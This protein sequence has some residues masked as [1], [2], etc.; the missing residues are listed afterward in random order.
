MKRNQ[1]LNTEYLN[2]KR[3]TLNA[4]FSLVE[5]LFY[6]VILS[7]ALLAVTQTLMVITRSYGILKSVQSIEQE[8]AFSL[9]R[10]MRE[11][12]NANAIDDA[13]SILGTTPGKLFLNSTEMSS[14]APTTVEFSVVN[15]NLSLKENGVVTGTLTSS[16][17]AVTALVFRKIN[18]AR[19]QGVKIEM[20]LTSGTGTAARTENF[21][22]TAVLRDSY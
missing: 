7:F 20:T 14:G 9:E 4:G 16:A 13:G 18:T 5:I 19:S 12:R 3:S 17:T 8:A 10:L 22:A 11:V 2:A 21:Y 1:Q 6:V 15:G